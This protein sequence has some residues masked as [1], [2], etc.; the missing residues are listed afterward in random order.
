M[1]RLVEF[2]YDDGAITKL[3]LEAFVYLLRNPTEISDC[4]E[5]IV[6]FRLESNNNPI[7]QYLQSRI[8]NQKMDSRIDNIFK[9]LEPLSWNGQTLSIKP[10]YED[11]LRSKVENFYAFLNT[12]QGSIPEHKDSEKYRKMLH[13]RY[14]L[15]Q[16]F[17]RS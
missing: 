8:T 5:N 10:E 3:E 1:L 6:R 17:E 4:V 16:Y 9:F 7:S 14:S 15:E 11:V 13:S 12:Y 2:G